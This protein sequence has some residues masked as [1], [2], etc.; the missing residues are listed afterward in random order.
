MEFDDPFKIIEE[1]ADKLLK[2]MTEF[3]DGLV[4]VFCV[5]DPIIFIIKWFSIGKCKPQ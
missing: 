2:E 1:R 3:A 4:E 5:L